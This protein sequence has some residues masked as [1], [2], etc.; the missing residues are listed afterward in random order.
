[1]PGIEKKLENKARDQDEYGRNVRSE[2]KREPAEQSRHHAPTVEDPAHP[3]VAIRPHHGESP[4]KCA[5]ETQDYGA[6][7][8]QNAPDQFLPRSIDREQRADASH[9]RHETRKP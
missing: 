7:S 6:V 5:D 9:E 2:A 3:I 4:V 1:M 8:D